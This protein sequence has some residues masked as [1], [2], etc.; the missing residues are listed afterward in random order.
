MVNITSAILRYHN[1]AEFHA[2]VQ[3]VIGIMELDK[4]TRLTDEELSII[5]ISA[6]LAIEIAE[7]K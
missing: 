2:K 6:A 3:E 4:P 7:R 1:D 5:S